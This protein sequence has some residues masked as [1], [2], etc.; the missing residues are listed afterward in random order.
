MTVNFTLMGTMHLRLLTLKDMIF[1]DSRE[2][3]AQECRMRAIT[4]DPTPGTE[5]ILIKGPVQPSY[6]HC[7]DRRKM[8]SRSFEPTHETESRGTPW[9]DSCTIGQHTPLLEQKALTKTIRTHCR[10]LPPNRKKLI[11]LVQLLNHC[12]RT[13]LGR[14]FMIHAPSHRLLT[15]LVADEN[16]WLEDAPRRQG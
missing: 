7:P 1:W 6:Q 14:K 9:T 3:R 2:V 12:Q 16:E 13:S 15:A 11:E 10:D 8:Q 4:N 5:V